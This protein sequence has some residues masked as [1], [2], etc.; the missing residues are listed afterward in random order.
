M[1]DRMLD[2]AMVNGLAAKLDQFGQ[3]L[4]REEQAVLAGLLGVASA[5]IEESQKAVEAGGGRVGVQPNIDVAGN[6]P[7]LSDALKASFTH[8]PV[9]GDGGSVSD[10]VGVGVGSVSWSKDYNMTAPDIGRVVGP[11]LRTPNV[12]GLRTRQ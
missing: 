8:V 6:I 9:G 3:N 10:S 7:N 5:T 1:P 4:T 11:N 12:P 2:R